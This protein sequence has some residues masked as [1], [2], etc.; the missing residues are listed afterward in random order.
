MLAWIWDHWLQLYR[1]SLYVET[2]TPISAQLPAQHR[3]TSCVFMGLPWDWGEF[4]GQSTGL[5]CKGP[6]FHL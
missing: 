2:A 6:S 1:N 5:A 4:K 3:A